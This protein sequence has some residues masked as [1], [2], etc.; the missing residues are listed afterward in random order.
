MKF[1]FAPVAALGVFAGLLAAQAPATQTAPQTNPPQSQPAAQQPATPPSGAPSSGGKVIF[2]RSTDESGETTT[3][4]GPA[5][6]LGTQA[7][8]P[9]ASDAERDAVTF[10]TYD[11]DVH[12]DPAKN[13]MAVRAVMKIRN[14]GKAALAHLPLE[15]S[16]TLTWQSIHLDGKDTLFTVA[17]LNS[18]TDHTGQLHEAAVTLAAAAGSDGQDRDVELRLTQ[19]PSRPTRCG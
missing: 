19:A 2:S 18:D 15:I 12:L 3:T 5:A 14:D 6:S 9:T 7:A 4:I 16:S 11:L 1:V 17:T 8:A 10:T 13:S